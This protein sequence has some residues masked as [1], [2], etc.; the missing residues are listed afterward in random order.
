MS[1][2]QEIKDQLNK[3]REEVKNMVE[4][5]THTSD[6]DYER[7]D[8]L[9]KLRAQVTRLEHARELQTQTNKDLEKNCQDLRYSTSK[10][11]ERARELQT[12]TNKDLEKNCQELKVYMDMLENEINRHETILKRYLKEED[13]RHRKQRKQESRTP[14]GIDPNRFFKS[15]KANMQECNPFMV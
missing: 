15:T 5:A 1:E 13:E 10:A 14:Y 9:N 8:Q 3:L 7:A 2:L 11:L 12:Q 4:V 6:E